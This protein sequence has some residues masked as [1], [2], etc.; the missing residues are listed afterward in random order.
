MPKKLISQE[1]SDLFRKTVENIHPLKSHS[2]KI[3]HPQNEPAD[4]PAP[5][6]IETWLGPE[7]SIHFAKPGLQRKII[8][9]LKQ[10][11]I[12]IEATVDLHRQTM[13]EAMITVSRFI[14]T[15]IQ[16]EKRWV[17]IIHGKGHF[18]ATDKPVLKSFLNQWLREHPDVL[19]FHSAKPKHGGTGALYVLLKR[20][21]TT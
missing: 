2:K 15:C 17:C 9:R 10:G 8:Q 12:T 13:N 18:S 5:E 20:R 16:Q 7:D 4:V 11:K 21:E 3:S 14:E 6:S 19:A 1:E